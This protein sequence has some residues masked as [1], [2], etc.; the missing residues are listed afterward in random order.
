MGLDKTLSV[1]IY[2]DPASYREIKLIQSTRRQTDVQ[3]VGNFSLEDWASLKALTGCFENLNTDPDQQNRLRDEN[4]TIYRLPH[5][6]LIPI[7]LLC[8]CPEN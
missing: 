4:W 6:D 7:L 2:M 5:N 8:N 1:L 3:C